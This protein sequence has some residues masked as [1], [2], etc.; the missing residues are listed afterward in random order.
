MEKTLELYFRTDGDKTVTI[1]V[2]APNQSLDL[3]TV[4]A[5]Q[6][7][8]IEA[9]CFSTSSGDLTEAVGASYIVKDVEP[10]A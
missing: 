7:K 4:N 6:E 9:N 10:L 8:I 3:A 2:K 5:A 1:V